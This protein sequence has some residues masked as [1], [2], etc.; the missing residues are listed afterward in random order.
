MQIKVT[1]RRLELTDKIKEKAN[2]EIEKLS[3]FFDNIVSANLVLSQ[4]NYRCDGELT[5]NVAK[6]KLI[7]KP[8]VRISSRPLIRLPTKWLH[9]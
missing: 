8:P 1:G 7:Q 3:K 9:S 2:G 5:M 6:S 4:Q